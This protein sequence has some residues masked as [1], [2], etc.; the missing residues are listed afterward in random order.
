MLK[1]RFFGACALSA[2]A[3]LAQSNSPGGPV[4]DLSLQKATQL[5]TSPAGNTNVQMARETERL[6]ASR[7]TAALAAPLLPSLDGSV[8]EQNQ[9]VNPQ[10]LGL[11]FSSPL[12][13]VPKGKRGPFY[14]F[15]ARARLNQNVLNLSAIRHWQAGAR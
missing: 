2:I 1:S 12:F 5:A 6:S 4:L 11:R 7:Y 3:C 13:T 15:H 10:A 9:T 8:A 14:I